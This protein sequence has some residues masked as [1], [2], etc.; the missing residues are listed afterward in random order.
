MESTARVVKIWRGVVVPFLKA[1]FIIRISCESVLLFNLSDISYIVA[2]WFGYVISFLI[3]INLICKVKNELQDDINE[4]DEESLSNLFYIV[5]IIH[6]PKETEY[7]TDLDFNH[8]YK[9][10]VMY[11][12]HGVVGECMVSHYTLMNLQLGCCYKAFKENDS[13]KFD[14]TK[15]VD[16]ESAYSIEK[17]LKLE[18]EL[19]AKSNDFKDSIDTYKI[20]NMDEGKMQDIVDGRLGTS[21][22][23][24]CIH[25]EHNGSIEILRKERKDTCIHPEHKNEKVSIEVV[26]PKELEVEP[27]KS[28][29]EA[30]DLIDDDL[31]NETAE[32]TDAV[33]SESIGKASQI[34]VSLSDSEEPKFEYPDMSDIWNGIGV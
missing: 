24:N 3:L 19:R 30:V 18:E 23:S 12:H 4:E 32:D 6:L 21:T 22:S 1:F 2:R 26:T 13:L 34:G 27:I 28:F 5:Q 20:S 31:D 16:S 10:L 7:E 25:S 15:T 29:D 9:V 33:L 14:L 8:K 11:T 17:V